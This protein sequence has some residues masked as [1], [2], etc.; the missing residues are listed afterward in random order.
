MLLCFGPN[1][2]LVGLSQDIDGSG[3]VGPLGFAVLCGSD[4]A[5]VEAGAVPGAGAGARTCGARTETGT[6]AVTGVGLE[7]VTEVR[8]GVVAGCESIAGATATPEVTTAEA[9]GGLIVW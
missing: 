7:V 1:H 4:C 6:G 5:A 2:S 8:G 3:P 9:G